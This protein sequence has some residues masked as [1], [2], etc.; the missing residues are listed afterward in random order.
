MFKPSNYQTNMKR[1]LSLVAAMI[2][3][4]TTIAQEYNTELYDLGQY[5]QRVYQEEPFDGVRIVENVDCCYLVSVVSE[6]PSDNE[7]ATNRKAEVKAL[8][9]A[10]TF[11]NGTRITQNTVLYTK[12]NS[13]GYS[14]EEIEDFIESYS[15]GYV[16]TMQIASTFK[17]RQKKVYVFCKKMPMPE[18]KGKK[19]RNR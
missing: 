18:K 6:K 19:K 5:V 14:Y 3:A 8:S 7:Y 16:Q 15:M 10:N 17:Y 1:I 2:I 11:L 4:A 9:Q 13:K 12:Q